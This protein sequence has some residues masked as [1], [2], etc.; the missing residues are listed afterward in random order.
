MFVSAAEID[1]VVGA[2]D[3]VIDD[4][5]DVVD[6]VAEVIGVVADIVDEDFASV[7]TDVEVDIIVVLD[8]AIHIVKRL[9]GAAPMNVSFVGV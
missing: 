7:D 8:P 3:V 6:V 9:E 4:K 1:E 2:E 5:S